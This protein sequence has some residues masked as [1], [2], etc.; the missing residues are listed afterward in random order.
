MVI[1]ACE[2]LARDASLPLVQEAARQAAGYYQNH[3]HRMA[4]GAFREASYAIGSGVIESGIK[5]TVTVRMKVAGASWTEAGSESTLKART[6]LVERLR[7][8]FSSL[9]LVA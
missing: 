3:A 5:Q 7:I 4:Y 8:T 6:A 2:A 9:P 1:Q